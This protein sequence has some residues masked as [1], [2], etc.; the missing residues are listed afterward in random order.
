MTIAANSLDFQCYPLGDSAVIIQF[1]DKISLAINQKIGAI[2]RFLDEYTFEGFIEYV[3][4][5][6]SI[7][8]YYQSDK[9]SYQEL[10]EMIEEMMSALPDSDAIPPSPVIEIPV[11]YGGEWGPDLDFVAAHNKLSPEDVISIHSNTDYLV[12]M[13]GFAPGF[14][15]LGGM[16]ERIATPRRDNPRASIF[17]GAVG[18]GGMQTGVYPIETPA[19]WQII[20]RAKVDLFDKESEHPVLLKAGDRVR[21]VPVE[22]ELLSDEYGI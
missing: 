9:V 11:M 20:G 2:C 3:P 10:E 21:F 1:D 6:S 16:D 14:P 17:P 8:I 7:A 18:I 22:A 19:G 12:Y 13:I 5:F 15:Y 4:A